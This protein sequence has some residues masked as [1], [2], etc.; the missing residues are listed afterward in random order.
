MCC[1]RWF[2]GWNAMRKTCRHGR[3]EST[4]WWNTRNPLLTR[5]GM[6][7]AQTAGPIHSH[8]LKAGAHC[9]ATLACLPAPPFRHPEPGSSLAL[10]IVER[11]CAI[12]IVVLPRVRSFKVSSSSDSVTLSRPLVGSSITRIGAFRRNARAKAIRCRW[13]PERLLPTWLHHNAPIVFTNGQKIPHSDQ[14]PGTTTGTSASFQVTTTEIGASSG[15]WESAR[16]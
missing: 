3:D 4:K 1:T 2:P 11:R 12:M 7:P 6:Y 15:T 13:P 9:R 14:R 5:R 10:S 16:L 8:L